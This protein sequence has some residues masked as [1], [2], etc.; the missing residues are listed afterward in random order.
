MDKKTFR[1]KMVLKAENPGEFE[2]EF[3]TLGVKDLDGDVTLPG[4]FQAQGVLIESW[5]HNYQQL[6]VGQGTIE[7]RADK[8]VVSGKFFLDTVN[9]AEH[10]HVVKE[11]GDLQ[12]WSYSF[13]ILEAEFGKHNDEDVRFLKKMD[14]IGVGPVMRGAGIDTRTTVIKGTGNNP[15]ESEGEAGDGKPSGISPDVVVSELELMELED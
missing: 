12:Q 2:A 11:L 10:H 8:A 15:D 1:A 5:N 6:P 3:A 13:N 14:V 9:G 4:A 7:E